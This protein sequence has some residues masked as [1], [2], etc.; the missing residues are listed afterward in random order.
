V[1]LLN[2][3][4]F[5]KKRNENKIKKRSFSARHLEKENNFEK[6]KT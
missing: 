4:S 1:G 5:K 2:Y 6:A 3:F